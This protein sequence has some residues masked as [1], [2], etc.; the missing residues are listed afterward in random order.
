MT[1]KTAIISVLV[2]LISVA[3]CAPS[4]LECSQDSDCVPAQCCHATNAVSKD[5]APNCQGK[6]CTLNCAPNTLDCGQG[7]IKCIQ[8]ECT[9]V[10][11]P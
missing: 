3:S 5:E 2:I 9:V 8:N 10:I 6:I 7:E 4:P 1:L 11:N